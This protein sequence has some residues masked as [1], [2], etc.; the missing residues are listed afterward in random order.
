MS[1]SGSYHLDTTETEPTGGASSLTLTQNTE[2]KEY[3]HNRNTEQMA[4]IKRLHA[5]M[6]PVDQGISTRRMCVKY[7]SVKLINVVTWNESH[8]LVPMPNDE[9][10]EE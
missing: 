2:A 9:A 3:W 6:E 4:L 10:V 1:W 7:P 8:T 5:H